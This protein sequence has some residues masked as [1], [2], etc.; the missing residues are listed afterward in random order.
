MNRVIKILIA[1]DFLMIRNGLRLMLENQNKVTPLITEASNGKEILDLIEGQE[2]DI[3]LLDIT[4]PEMDGITVLKKLKD[5]QCEI[6]VLI[7]T[8]HKEESVIKQAL[9]HGAYGYILKN[10]GLEELIKAIQTVLKKERYFS[11]E[12][13]QLLFHSNKVNEKKSIIDFESNLTRREIQI[14]S[15]IIKEK[16]NQEIANELCV[17]KRTIEGHRKNIMA[18]LNVKSTIGL[19]KYA[20]KNGFE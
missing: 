20:L 16:T 10:S 19:V 6:P 3:I 7:L 14:L 11:N 15:F 9:D 5:I 12:I 18:K 1:D 8:M 17:S 2:F 13:T 4:M